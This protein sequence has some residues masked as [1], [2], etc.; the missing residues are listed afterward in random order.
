MAA[1]A[2]AGTYSR[3]NAVIFLPEA[4]CCG[5]VRAA[6]SGAVRERDAALGSTAGR[7]ELGRATADLCEGENPTRDA[8]EEA[9]DLGLCTDAA[10]VHVEVAGA[11]ELPACLYVC[12]VV[13]GQAA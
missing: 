12:S 6:Y 3:A 10:L 7:D 11:V 4:R 8:G 13:L 2:R 1:L 5:A 9:N